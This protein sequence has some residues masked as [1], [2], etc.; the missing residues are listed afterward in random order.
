M[1]TLTPKILAVATGLLTL[2]LA[3]RASAQD[4]HVAPSHD[5]ATHGTLSFAPEHGA[6][7][8][9][10]AASQHFGSVR[11]PGF[12]AEIGGHLPGTVDLHPLPDRFVTQ[13]PGARTYQYDIVNDRR[14]IVEPG[15]RRIIHVYD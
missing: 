1:R 9:E 14:V 13:L 15:T 2:S 12:H 10:H 5:R 3:G 7:L 6:I 8:Q 11:D 4:V